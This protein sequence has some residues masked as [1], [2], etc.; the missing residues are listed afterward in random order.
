MLGAVVQLLLELPPQPH[1]LLRAKGPVYF[2]R[3]REKVRLVQL[4]PG[5]KLPSWLSGGDLLELLSLVATGKIT[6][7]EAATLDAQGK[8]SPSMPQPDFVEQISARLTRYSDALAALELPLHIAPSI[9]SS[10]TASGFFDAAVKALQTHPDLID[11]I[12]QGQAAQVPALAGTPSGLPPP[13]DDRNELP[14]FTVPATARRRS[15]LFLHHSYYH[16]NYLAD[17]LRRRGWDA[18]TV[19]VTPPSAP[20]RRLYV[21]EDVSL[22]HDD[23]MVRRRQVREFLRTV[24]ERFEALHFYGQWLP[25]MFTRT[26][27]RPRSGP[28]C[29]GTCSNCVGTGS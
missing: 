3:R 26:S 28:R 4:G 12:A 8:L 19:S 15:A 1:D 23:P 24:P 29:H 17:G 22:Y 21:G 13:F 9:A 7:I 27:T 25:S 5:V 10:Q 11:F 2:V 6:I 14:A 16:F 18:L 20:E